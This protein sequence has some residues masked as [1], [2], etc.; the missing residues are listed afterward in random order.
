MLIR[1]WAAYLSDDWVDTLS[2]LLGLILAGA[3]IWVYAIYPG[4]AR[5]KAE[6][7]SAVETKAAKLEVALRRTCYESWHSTECFYDATL[8]PDA[9]SKAV[10]SANECEIGKLKAVSDEANMITV[11]T[12]VEVEK[13][14]AQIAA[15]EAA[16]MKKAID[17]S[18]QRAVLDKR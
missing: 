3:M 6:L 18:E 7:P 17:L 16:R 1:K 2:G 8:S 14:C 11:A 4:Q 13:A 10:S 15:D 9:L 12:L 5:A